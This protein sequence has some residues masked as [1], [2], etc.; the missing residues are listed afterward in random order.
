[1]GTGEGD[2]EEEECAGECEE[3][4]AY[5]GDEPVKRGRVCI[6]VLVLSALEIK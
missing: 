3:V 6:I 2:P 1:M 5:C 4:R